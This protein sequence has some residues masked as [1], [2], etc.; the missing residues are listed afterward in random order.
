MPDVE[1]RDPAVVVLVP[2]VPKAMLAEEERLLL[3]DG[4]GG[5]ASAVDEPGRA[6]A[7]TAAAEPRR[8]DEIGGS[9]GT[10]VTFDGM[11]LSIG[12]LGLCCGL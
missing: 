1:S 5:T 10:K 6:E 8:L 9:G 12:D 4:V 2:G 3:A 7:E 11:V